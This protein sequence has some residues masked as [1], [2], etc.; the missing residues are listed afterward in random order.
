MQPQALIVED[1]NATST[2]L[3]QVV[4]SAG[5]EPLYTEDGAT[6]L[7]I[8]EQITPVVVMLDV[9]LPHVNGLE[10]LEYIEQTPRLNSSFVI[11]ISSHDP[12]DYGWETTRANLY[13]VKPI[14]VKELRSILQAAIEQLS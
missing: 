6:A 4:R 3:Q 8:L 5:L 1:D 11:V 12:T 14:R 2:L 10:V 9:L 13:Y 7:Q